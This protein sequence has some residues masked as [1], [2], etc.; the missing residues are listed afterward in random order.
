MNFKRENHTQASS[1]TGAA[2]ACEPSHHEGHRP[3]FS[4][5]FLAAMMLHVSYSGLQSMLSKPSLS[6]KCCGAVAHSGQDRARSACNWPLEAVH[7]TAMAL[8]HVH[9]PDLM[10]PSAWAL[11]IPHLLY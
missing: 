9:Q 10:L 1:D 2:A 11:P 6:A 4:C 5:L 3:N 7:A 8:L